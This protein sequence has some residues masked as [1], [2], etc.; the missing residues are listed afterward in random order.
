MRR[1]EHGEATGTL[2]FTGRGRL[3]E[4]WLNDV[5]KGEGDGAKKKSKMRLKYTDKRQQHNAKA[6][7][8]GRPADLV[9]TWARG[10]LQTS[11]TGRRLQDGAAPAPPAP[12]GSPCRGGNRCHQSGP[13]P[14]PRMRP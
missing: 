8:W 6:K 12:G 11:L 4:R 3:P 13:P 1:G 9:T 5:N 14:S 2:G 7:P 10:L